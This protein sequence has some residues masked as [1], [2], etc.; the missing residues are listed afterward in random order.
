EVDMSEIE[1]DVDTAVPVGL[2]TNELITNSLKHAFPN[3][4]KG[5]ILITL[6][7]DEND[8]LKL[9][10]VDNG[11][12]TATG[13]VVKKESGFG[14]LLIQLL[15]TQLGGKLEQSTKAGTST[16]IQFPRQEKSVA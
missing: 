3:K 15:T 8:L 7:Q 9:H 6:T 16:I 1:L 2:I 10:V 5:Q 11:Q 12:N 13:S 14:T 4:Q